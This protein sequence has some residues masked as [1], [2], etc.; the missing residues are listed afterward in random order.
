MKSRKFL[1][2]ALLLAIC[3]GG[4]MVRG[5]IMLTVQSPLDYVLS[6]DKD[7]IHERLELVQSAKGQTVLDQT[8]RSV[9]DKD[10]PDMLAQ[11]AAIRYIREHRR[12]EYLPDVRRLLSYYETLDLDSTW[13]TVGPNGDRRMNSTK[14]SALVSD[15]LWTIN[16]IEQ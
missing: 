4:W 1:Y 14:N 3:I 6:G 10:P 7:N 2:A 5:R 12:L 13:V 11:Q 16:E 15:L 9:I 8:I